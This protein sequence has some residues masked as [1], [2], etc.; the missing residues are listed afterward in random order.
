[1]K[2]GKSVIL[3]GL[4][5]ASGFAASQPSFNYAAVAD[6]DFGDDYEEPEEP[7]IEP[8][9]NGYVP[10]GNHQLVLYGYYGSSSN[11]V[12]NFSL[13]S[14]V[15]DAE[16]KTYKLDVFL[17]KGDSIC[18]YSLTKKAFLTYVNNDEDSLKSYEDS[19][20]V[21]S[22]SGSRFDCVVSGTYRFEIDYRAEYLNPIWEAWKYENSKITYISEST[23]YPNFVPSGLAEIRI[24]GK[25]NG[26]DYWKMDTYDIFSY[27]E[28]KKEYYFK[29]DFDKGDIFCPYIGLRNIY[30]YYLNGNEY[31]ENMFAAARLKKTEQ[32]YFECLDSGTYE[33]TFSSK[34]EII[35]TPKDLW[36]ENGGCSIKFTPCPIPK[37]TDSLVL[38]GYYGSSEAWTYS[39]ELHTFSYN[40]DTKAYELLVALEKGDIVTPYSITREKPIGYSDDESAYNRQ[41]ANG[42]VTKSN[43]GDRYL[44]NRSG[45]YKFSISY[46]N[47]Y[48]DPIKLAWKD[49]R[50][51][52]QYIDGTTDYPNFTP[53]G[54]AGIILA[55]KF[56]GRSTW[57]N[58][59]NDAFIY[60]SGSE[61]YT[62]TKELKK[63]D[64]FCPYI[65][66]RNMYIYYLDN[67]NFAS[68][69]YFEAK[70][71]K[72]GNYFECLQDGTYT[73]NIS[74]KAEIIMTPK[75]LWNEN[76]KST[77]AF[78]PLTTQEATGNATII[79]GRSAGGIWSETETPAYTFSYDVDKSAYVLS[80]ELSP[81]DE[82]CPFVKDKGYIYRN[83][84]R[85]QNYANVLGYSTVF[86]TEKYFKALK[87]GT[88]TFTIDDSIEFFDADEFI[89]IWDT[90]SIT[91]T[92]KVEPTP[93]V[94]VNEPS[95]NHQLVLYGY[96]G[97]SSN[98]VYNQ[99]MHSFV[100]NETTKC[101]ELTVFLE[102]GDSVAPYSL[103][104]KAFLN[105]VANDVN[106]AF[107]YE[108]SN[109]KQSKTGERFDVVATGI[110]K[111]EISYK[112]EYLNPIWNAWKES[113]SKI[114]YISSS[115]EYPNFTPTGNGQLRM[116]GKVNDNWTSDTGDQF[117]YDAVRKGYV[118]T[119]QYKKGDVFCPYI[120]TR[121]VYVY[122]LKGNE[123]A[124]SM[125]ADAL[126]KC[127]SQNYFECGA[128]GIFEFFISAKAEIIQTPKNLWNENGGSYI[129]FTPT[130]EPKDDPIIPDTPVAV[131]PKGTE[132]VK[133]YGK[134]GE[135]ATWTVTAEDTFKYDASRKGYVFKKEMKEGDT[136][137]P[138]IS[139]RGVYATYPSNSY[140]QSNMAAA[141]LDKTSSGYFE[142]KIAGTYEFFISGS[143][144]TISTIDNLWNEENGSYIRYAS[145]KD[146]AV[147]FIARTED[148][149]NLK[150][151][152]IGEKIQEYGYNGAV[153]NASEVIKLRGMEEYKVYRVSYN[154]SI[155]SKILIQVNDE[156]IADHEDLVNN[157][158]YTKLNLV[159][160]EE[161]GNVLEFLYLL[162]DSTKT[163][164]Y[165]GVDYDHCLQTIDAENARKLVE[166]Y[167][168]FSG[169]AKDYINSSKFTTY[170]E[171]FTE[172]KDMWISE[173][174][175]TV[176]H[177]NSNN[178][179]A[180]FFK[181]V[182]LFVAAV[183]IIGFAGYF[184]LAYKRNMEFVQP[185]EENAL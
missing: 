48:L 94:V 117:T 50:S 51:T 177:I 72:S 120:G 181:A 58:T 168:S 165:N 163:Y 78:A 38:Y 22:S 179:V 67:N 20:L 30:V 140:G 146:S 149:I 175:P 49:W 170:N 176:E 103:T 15:Y 111:F 9:E 54:N 68:G 27:D 52:I 33:F 98:W 47:E 43:D 87:T 13:H 125:F 56:D 118:L 91:F 133:L 2:L 42:E 86:K 29:M 151:T 113:G 153:F 126:L 183:A 7:V 66:S 162:E 82:V 169:L 128:S 127:T 182:G 161:I 180:D 24:V 137:C 35:P 6:D 85:T 123:Y 100:Y 102:K 32:N 105:Y 65:L 69:T 185:E 44:I 11:W 167:E 172:R 109:L 108:N 26:L 71:K 152:V 154:S 139:I 132:I 8:D 171:D 158:V 3:L 28:T 81:G 79:L 178:N 134:F 5:F 39:P 83:Q 63:G 70:V 19:L 89:E 4:L 147:Y 37:E 106:A 184:L 53:N 93:S 34:T 157:K 107:A 95:G 14:F 73:F 76:H 101:Y 88:Y 121:N 155:S 141:G 104:K 136:F 164:N 130:G 92:P 36:N 129:S 1:M 150:A 124:E 23:D 40:P 41:R 55:G 110:Y 160:K 144:E 17:E 142:C 96:Y 159:G 16:S 77:I 143:C 138:Y 114:T 60:N 80:V 173:I 25:Y 97:G 75:D 112:C 122:Y 12:Y 99:S 10:T 116:A 31:A 145:G 21:E 45:T 119:K 62:Y 135:N 174:M 61:T 64:T 115:T 46:K 156:I 18:P 90:S 166:K 131:E 74:A 59:A 57:S 84:Y 148:E